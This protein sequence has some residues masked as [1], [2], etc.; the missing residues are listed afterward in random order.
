MNKKIFN[1]LFDSILILLLELFFISA[2][3]LIIVF[4]VIKN[5]GTNKTTVCIVFSAIFIPI[6]I[7]LFIMLLT[8]CFEWWKIADDYVETKK[9]LKK[10]TQIKVAE[11]ISINEE[12]VPAL[13]LGVYKTNAVIIKTPAKK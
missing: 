13:I 10:R 4:G 7:L 3:S 1:N 8:G 12:V 5:D 6:I 2:Y 9:V 11:I